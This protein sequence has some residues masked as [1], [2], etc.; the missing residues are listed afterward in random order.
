MFRALSNN[1]SG[2]GS[3]V[4]NFWVTRHLCYGPLKVSNEIALQKL[5]EQKDIFTIWK[6]VVPELFFSNGRISGTKRDILDPLAPKFSSCPGL[7]PTLSWKWPR[8]TLS[9][10]FSLFLEREPFF[11]VF[12]VGHFGPFWSKT[13]PWDPFPTCKKETIPG[14]PIDRF[15]ECFVI[16]FIS[17]S[18]RYFHSDRLK[19]HISWFLEVPETKNH[20]N[21]TPK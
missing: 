8:P 16:S 14:S 5:N 4:L 2:R 17:A 1:M 12:Q 6:I 19:T 13:C 21:L 20:H 9:S 18:F 11:G 10:S 3:R 15:P 7:S